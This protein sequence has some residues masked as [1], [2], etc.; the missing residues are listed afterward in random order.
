MDIEVEY[1]LD[2]NQEHA[3][4]CNIK[5]NVKSKGYGEFKLL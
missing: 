3:A 1:A 5:I 2:I 4:D